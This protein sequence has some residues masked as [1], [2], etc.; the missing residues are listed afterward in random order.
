MLNAQLGLALKRPK[1]SYN[2]YVKSIQILL[3]TTAR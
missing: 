2:C 1:L 3:A